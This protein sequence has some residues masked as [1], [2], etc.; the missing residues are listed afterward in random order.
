MEGGK[1]TNQ[2]LFEFFREFRVFRG[3]IFSVLFHN[4]A[5]DVVS[6]VIW[7]IVEADRRVRGLIGFGRMRLDRRSCGN[8]NRECVCVLLEFVERDPQRSRHRHTFRSTCAVRQNANA[9][10]A[11]VFQSCRQFRLHLDSLSDDK[12]G[13]KS[14][15]AFGLDVLREHQRGGAM[16]M[17][18]G[19]MWEGFDLRSRHRSRSR[20]ETMRV[21]EAAYRSR[22][23]ARRGTAA[24]PAPIALADR[25][26]RHCSD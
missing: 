1:I 25:L 14:F 18:A 3:Q 4:S 24:P 7:Q 12:D 9:R 26:H 11:R 5:M 22:R 23:N 10:I 19:T 8:A 13:F 6:F 21:C 15:Q 16:S 17:K 2:T 20:D